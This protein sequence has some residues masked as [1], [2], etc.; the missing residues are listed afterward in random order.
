MTN[1]DYDACYAALQL[2][3]GASLALINESWRKLSRLHHPDL[4][5][6]DARAYKKAL[7]KQKQI[8]NA[9]DIL[10][11]WFEANPGAVPP[12]SFRTA[13]NSQSRSGSDFCNSNQKTNQGSSHPESHARNNSHHGD[14]GF[15]TDNSRGRDPDVLTGWFKASE[16]HLTP[17]QKFAQKL[18]AEK[19]GS[20]DNFEG[21]AVIAAIAAMFLPMWTVVSLLR[22]LVPELPSQLPDCLQLGVLCVSGYVSCYLFRWFF[23]EREIIE[24]QAKPVYLRAD[25]SPEATILHLRAAIANQKVQT[26]EW[27]FSVSEGVHAAT[28]E[29]EEIL[30]KDFNFKELN[31]KRRLQVRFAAKP[32]TRGT[33]VALEIRARS[34]VNSFSCNALA[35]AIIADLKTHL[36][37]IAA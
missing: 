18:G 24:L 17:L 28:L 34:P 25:Q 1:I 20:K 26:A 5:A 29:Y 30:F 36:H 16:L 32:V 6:C 11:K 8:N 10:K 37:E 35:K 12:S 7:E 21:I 4:F 22:A 2:I 19:T 23:A 31:R 13:G 3:P 15:R 9:R 33:V 27:M 14:G